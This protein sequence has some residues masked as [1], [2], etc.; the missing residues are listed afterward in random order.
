MSCITYML[1]NTYSCIQFETLTS[2]KHINI[3]PS[4]MRLFASK[5]YNQKPLLLLG[6]VEPS[7]DT[8]V[9]PYE[10]ANIDVD[11]PIM[12][13]AIRQMRMIPYLHPIL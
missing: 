2:S 10:R 1:L 3:P 13:R 9:R 4:N 5:I 8:I 11:Q 6:I 12:Q 7:C